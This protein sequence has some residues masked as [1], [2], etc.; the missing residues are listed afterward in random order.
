MK[1]KS[2][3][4][5]LLVCF[6]L[7]YALLSLA[8]TV[9]STFD[10][11]EKYQL[12]RNNS[13][14]LV[15]ES[16]KA[17]LINDDIAMGKLILEKSTSLDI[18]DYACLKKN[19]ETLY[20]IYPE[21]KFNTCDMFSDFDIPKLDIFLKREHLFFKKLQ[22]GNYSLVVGY[23]MTWYHFVFVQHKEN[24]IP[25]LKDLFII[26]LFVGILIF[27][28]LKDFVMIDQL[29][30]KGD[31]SKLSKMRA[32]SKEAQTLID[33]TTTMDTIN[34]KNK[35]SINVLQ[36][37]VGEALASEIRNET[38]SLTIIPVS[39]VRIDLN[40]YTQIFLEKKEEHIVSVLNE[41]FEVT[42]DIINRYQGEIYQ[43]IGDE[44]IF[45][46]KSSKYLTNRNTNSASENAS[47]NIQQANAL[48]HASIN[49]NAELDPN[50]KALFCVKAIF[51]W[52]K[53]LDK[54]I[55]DQFGHRFLLKSSI[56]NG[57]LK[58]VKLNTGFA[59]AGVP[60]IESVRLLGSVSD[61]SEN[62]LIVIENDYQ[63]FQNFFPISNQKLTHLK[64]FEEKVTVFEIKEFIPVDE[65]FTKAIVLEDNELLRM[66]MKYLDYFK[67]Q[68]DIIQ[69]LV[70]INKYFLA[71]NL[72]PIFYLIQSLKKSSLLISDALIS[73]RLYQILV[74]HFQQIQSRALEYSFLPGMILL[75]KNLVHKDLWSTQWN[76]LL[77]NY[78]LSTNPR[79]V[80]NA[81][82]VFYF[83]H[84][85]I[86]E[87]KNILTNWQD[88]NRISA[89]YI[90]AL[91]KRDITKKEADMVL[92][93]LSSDNPLFQASALYL[94]EELVRYYSEKDEVVYNTNEVISKFKDEGLRL[95]SSYNQMVQ[96]RAEM[97]LAT[98]HT[99]NQKFLGKKVS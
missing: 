17:F 5:T 84:D 51:E 54:K 95:L 44:I 9:L 76:Q 58:F 67:S 15:L 70:L 19:D 82:D 28:I 79:I 45:I 90:L 2:F 12:K 30:K 41:Y 69:S 91:L 96:S 20:Q 6:W 59:F 13:I 35:Q 25:F 34:T 77:Q 1:R 74:D 87:I 72:T 86:D 97:L 99:I 32:T 66:K 68:D 60:L 78:L 61:K 55:N 37:T 93:W 88:N 56:S 24:I 21:N 75:I 43:I 64:G 7:G 23:A 85:K 50:L 49:S 53:K 46:F 31:K 42:N 94:I 89:L 48:S 92:T 47:Q 10:V 16:V 14:D 38:E 3:V 8:Q 33:S 40:G 29:L 22:I 83:N 27:L 52:S 71:N 98:V 62:T 65:Y 81:S 36:N 63:D 4:L 73:Q 11:K 18:V 26:T 80:A 57:Y 39:V